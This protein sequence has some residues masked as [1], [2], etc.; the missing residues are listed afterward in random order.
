MDII[1]VLTEDH[2]RLVNLL[3]KADTLRSPAA[4]DQLFINLVQEIS[5]HEKAEQSAVWPLLRAAAAY[6]VNLDL[7]LGAENAL[8][9]LLEE[10]V[11]GLGDEDI[12][13]WLAGIRELLAQHVNDETTL[14]FPLLQQHLDHALRERA[15]DAY[16]TAKANGT[17]RMARLNVIMAP[18]LPVEQ[19]KVD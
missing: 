16:L 4:N 19:L 8:Q 12:A 18:D 15:G 7:I 1:N 14:V 6:E 17:A 13:R 10:L 5:L 2:Q 9:D 3:D 11:V